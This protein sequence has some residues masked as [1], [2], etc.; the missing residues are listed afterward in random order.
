VLVTGATGF[1]GRRLVAACQRTHARPVIALVRDPSFAPDNA[2][3]RRRDLF[4]GVDG[5]DVTMGDVALPR[6]GLDEAAY[7]ELR[8]SVGLVIHCA[9]TIRLGGDWDDHAAANVSGTAEVARFCG[10]NI[11]W[12]HISTLSVFVNTS[13]RVGRHVPAKNPRPEAIAYGGYAQ[14]K[15]AAEAIARACG[16]TIY[17]LGLL[18]GEQARENDQLSMTIRAIEKLGAVPAGCR[19][20]RFDVTPVA[21][22]AAAIATIVARGERGTHHIAGGGV[23]CGELVER[24]RERGV[25]VDEVARPVWEERARALIDD[26]DI[27]MAI[28]SFS[29]EP[30]VDLFL[31]TGA[32]F[33]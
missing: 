10:E 17:R 5:V 15:I 26:A 20:R 8:E 14:T 1:L 22:A 3:D 27:A 9:A 29:G 6:F 2:A 19:E 4:C 31:A 30:E 32:E 33:S 11:P 28:A 13:D 24:M 16:A 25:R 21:M 18:V 23:T 12:H 7:R